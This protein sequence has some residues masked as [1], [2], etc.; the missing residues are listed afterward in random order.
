M[1]DEEFIKTVRE[2]EFMETVL[3]IAKQIEAIREREHQLKRQRKS[4]EYKLG[5]L[6]ASRSRQE[7]GEVK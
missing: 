7:I 3:E 6:L 1:T 4:K 5:Q 2:E